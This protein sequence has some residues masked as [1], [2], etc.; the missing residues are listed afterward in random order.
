LGGSNTSNGFHAAKLASSN[1]TTW[2]DNQLVKANPAWPLGYGQYIYAGDPASTKSNSAVALSSEVKSAA[3]FIKA[4][5]LSESFVAFPYFA[6]Y[7]ALVQTS[8]NGGVSLLANTY[9]LCKIPDLYLSTTGLPSGTVIQS[10]GGYW[11]TAAELLLPVGSET[12][13]I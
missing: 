5:S 11:M 3:S 7:G 9:P 4:E 1:T 10:E 6:M 13:L 8:A 2:G 12:T